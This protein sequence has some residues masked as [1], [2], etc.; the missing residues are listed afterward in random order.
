M[1]KNIKTPEDMGIKLND[2]LKD[3]WSD[4]EKSR[5]LLESDSRPLTTP[6]KMFPR[7]IPAPN[8]AVIASP[9][10]I[11]FAAVISILFFSFSFFVKLVI[12]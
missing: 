6:L 1:T 11:I 12:C 7:P 5:C 8:P 3:G 4:R 2:I 10:P 9:A